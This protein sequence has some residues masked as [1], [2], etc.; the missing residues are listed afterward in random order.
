VPLRA[1]TPGLVGQAVK[2]STSKSAE[3]WMYLEGVIQ[4]EVRENQ[5]LYKVTFIRGI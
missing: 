3:M 2:P 1:A 5:M 4:T